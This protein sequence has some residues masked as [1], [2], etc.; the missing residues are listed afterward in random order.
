MC[1]TL[2]LQMSFLQG[3]VSLDADKSGLHS[4]HLTPKLRVCLLPPHGHLFGSPSRPQSARTHQLKA[5]ARA[6][7]SP[8][9][10]CAGRRYGGMTRDLFLISMD[11]QAALLTG[12][13]VLILDVPDRLAT[14]RHIL[15]TLTSTC[16]SP[17][18]E[19]QISATH[20]ALTS[21]SGGSAVLPTQGSREK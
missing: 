9:H 21:F 14:V 13:C 6:W 16:R 19:P 7:T 4:L 11:T 20:M 8:G 10:L 3:N 15:C 12:L 2:V 18:G 1:S 5:P 17:H